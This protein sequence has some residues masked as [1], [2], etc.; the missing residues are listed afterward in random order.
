MRPGTGDAAGCKCDFFRTFR[1]KV[2]VFFEISQKI[3]GERKYNSLFQGAG[4]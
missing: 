3:F 2:R 4:F 1:G